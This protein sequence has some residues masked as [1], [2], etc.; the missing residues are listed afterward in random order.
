MNE[1][2]LEKVNEDL[3]GDTSGSSGAAD[4]WVH[5]KA[6]P[7]L[8]DDADTPII[9]KAAVMCVVKC[10]VINALTGACFAGHGRKVCRFTEDR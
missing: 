2:L 1:S 3:G 9:G 4:R 5:R 10:R 7:H 6:C 8:F